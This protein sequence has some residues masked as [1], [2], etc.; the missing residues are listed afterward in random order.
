ML[1]SS[2][3]THSVMFHH[4]HNEKHIHSQGSLSSSDFIDII[5]WLNKK[6][7]ILQPNEYLEKFR[8]KTIKSS[9]ICL[10]FD[11][12]LKCQYDI[13]IPILNQFKIKAFFFVY[14]SAFTD[15][16]DPLEIYRY[17]RTSSF[18]N[19]DEF[20]N[21]F[22]L[23]VKSHNLKK[24]N[25]HYLKYKSLNYLSEFPFYSE[26]DKWFRYLRDK[27]L[28]ENEYKSIMI[29]LMSKKNF[30]IN[31]A[32]KHLWMSEQE[33]I[34][35]FNEGHLIGLHSYSHPTKMSKLTKFEQEVEY[36]KNYNHLSKL[37][38]EPIKTMSHPCGDY[39]EITLGILSGMNIE[40]GFRSSMSI[41]NI[42]SP[43]EIPRED[44]ANIL[45]KVRNEGN[46]F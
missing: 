13:A 24:Y 18:N 35:I 44:H 40:I 28:K 39:N 8:N 10:S 15:N 5:E 9:D 26:N 6:F 11:D 19:I 23:I 33:L 36:N 29:D 12:S 31:K 27:Y 1:D 22:F 16:P 32:I 20:Y 4:F 21:D 41:L 3:C 45:K 17:F 38:G 42:R 2:P 34:E 46:N 7:E 30:D 14:S 43:L 37:L 25:N